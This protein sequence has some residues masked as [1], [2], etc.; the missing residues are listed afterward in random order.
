MKRITIISIIGIAII[1]FVHLTSADPPLSTNE[2]LKIG[3]EVYLQFLWMVDGAFNDQRF[4]YTFKVNNH[5]LKDE[6]KFFQ[7]T[8]TNAKD[9]CISSNFES[10][11][12]K[13]FSSQINYDQV[14]SDG[15]VHTWYEKKNNKYVFANIN[16]CNSV[17]MS[18]NHHLTVLKIE[19]GQ[20]TYK[21]QFDNGN[22]I[23]CEKFFAIHYE[24]ASWKITRAYYHDLCGIDYN[25]IG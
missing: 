8:Y 15:V 20:I 19:R 25:I 7:C 21:V 3:E 16:T 23:D 6:D 14:Y 1:S 13:L 24:D 11:F 2:A 4:N 18:E 22:Y 9:S 12:D 10:A 17:R 5:V